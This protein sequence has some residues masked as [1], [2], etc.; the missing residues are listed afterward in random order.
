MI[1]VMGL[2][3]IQI[4]DKSLLILG[5][6]ELLFRVLVFIIKTSNYKYF[7]FDFVYNYYHHFAHMFSHDDINIV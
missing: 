3:A 6:E 5:V 2:Y 4:L 1:I 7:D